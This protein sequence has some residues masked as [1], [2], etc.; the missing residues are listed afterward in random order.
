M[1]WGSGEWVGLMGRLVWGHGVG[2]Y[3]PAV[4]FCPAVGAVGWGF[5]VVVV[6]V[7]SLSFCSRVPEFLLVFSPHAFSHDD[8]GGRDPSSPSSRASSVAC[9]IA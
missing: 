7:L 6:V 2:D 8:V 1:H 4:G 5:V 9:S 3:C